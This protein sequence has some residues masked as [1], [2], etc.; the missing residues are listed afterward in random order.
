M[1]DFS[2]Y[3]V[4]DTT[5][6]VYL[7][8]GQKRITQYVSNISLSGADTQTTR[9]LTFSIVYSPYDGNVK[10]L[11]IKL[12][13]KVALYESSTRIFYGIV[14]TRERKS[15]VG[16]LQYT[17]K[18]YMHYLLRST[19]TYKFENK[20]AEQI[21]KLVCNDVGVPTGKLISTKVNIPKIFF[22]GRPIYEIIMASYTQAAKKDGNKYMPVMDGKK[23]MIIKKGKIVKEFLLQT[24]INITESSYQETTD[25]MVNKVAIYDSNHKQ[26]GS[27]KAENAINKYGVYQAS[28][29]VESGNGKTEAKNMLQDVTKTATLTAFGDI[30][31]VS[32]AAIKIKDTR[33]GLVGTYWIKSDTHT[34]DENGQYTMSL[35]IEFKNIMETFE[36]DEENETEHNSTTTSS[37]GRV[38]NGQKVR[39]K[40]TAYYPANNALEGGFLDAL[41]NKLDPSKN[42][43]A[44]PASVPFHTMIQILE[45]GTSRDGQEYEVL[46]RGGAI[47]IESGNVYHFDILMATNEE[48]NSWGVKMGYAVIGDG[49]GYSTPAGTGSGNTSVGKQAVQLAQSLIRKN[50][51]TQSSLRTQA[52]NGYSDCSSLCWKIYEKLGIYVGTWTGE[53]VTKG[54][55][56]DC[57][58][59]HPNQGWPDENKLQPGD[60]IFFGSGSATHVEMYVRKG[61]CIGHGSGIGPN[62]HNLQSYCLS[63]PSGYYQTRRYT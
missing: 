14:T 48:C 50:Q 58:T 45:T 36:P 30:R 43:M 25:N 53:Q 3:E 2:G 39:A 16:S 57:V 26:I 8:D 9:T 32:G 4:G 17:A 28:L 62:E 38:L 63:H 21:T 29:T 51:Y 18:D 15:Q 1:V 24:G 19:G 22:S 27:I 40:Y 55:Q 49:T 44:A 47:V 20:K 31:C 13:D 42:T 10:K 41:G 23:L 5:M 46:D 7:N 33:T 60:L 37:F 52:F 6:N 56:V 34:W 12:G 35:E 61:V 11:D 59:Q 54:Y